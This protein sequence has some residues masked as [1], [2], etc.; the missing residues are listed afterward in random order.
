M[1]SSLLIT[2]T[3]VT[4]GIE[5]IIFV[6]G[7]AL[8]EPGTSIPIAAIVGVICGLICGFGI[9]QFASRTSEFSHALSAR[10]GHNLTTVKH[11][12]FSLYA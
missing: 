1:N 4:I 10:E 5:A 9:Y 11:S 3:A 7:V 2:I 12:R 6:G 8:G